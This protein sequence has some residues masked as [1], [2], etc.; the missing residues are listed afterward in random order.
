M[1]DLFTITY[2]RTVDDYLP[3][4]STCWSPTRR[5]LCQTPPS[6]APV[7]ELLQRITCIADSYDDCSYLQ[8]VAAR[9]LTF[10]P[11]TSQYFSSRPATR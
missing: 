1:D 2:L 9:K 11:A 3:S 6:G 10:P 4:C 8:D 5:R 7:T